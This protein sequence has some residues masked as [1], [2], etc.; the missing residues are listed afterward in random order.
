MS[1]LED[2]AT[3]INS[4][5]PLVRS[6]DRYHLHGHRPAGNGSRRCSTANVLLSGYSKSRGAS[7]AYT[8]KHVANTTFECHLMNL[9]KVVFGFVIVLAL[10]LNVAFVLGGSDENL[11][12]HVFSSP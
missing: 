6:D 2:A 3:G 1:N 9:E 7:N 8:S 5:R 12:V 4:E 11:I 10:T